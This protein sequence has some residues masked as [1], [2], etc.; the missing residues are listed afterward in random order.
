[1]DDTADTDSSDQPNGVG[2]N[3]APAYRAPFR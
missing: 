2:V 1:M 3:P